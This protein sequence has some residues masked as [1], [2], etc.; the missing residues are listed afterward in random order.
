VS[1]NMKIPAAIFLAITA[2]LSPAA[3]S[4]NSASTNG[5]TLSPMSGP[6]GTL[7]GVT[8]GPDKRSLVI[9]YEFSGRTNEQI[10][11]L[12]KDIADFQSCSWLFGRGVALALS[13]AD[14]DIYWATGYFAL[15]K[16]LFPRKIR[17]PG[18]YQLLG[19]ANTRGD[20]IVV[21]AID[22]RQDEDTRRGWMYI[23]SCP[24]AADVFVKPPLQTSGF[25]YVREFEV[26]RK[27]VDL[28]K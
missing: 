5:P 9:H 6:P 19:I 11:S 22:H 1:N 26:P 13:D 2:A 23:N 8:R 7:L 28:N 10:V 14:G 3:E 4:I 17:A 12:A 21:S 24:P 27:K 18:G 16:P 20:T 15:S 25:D